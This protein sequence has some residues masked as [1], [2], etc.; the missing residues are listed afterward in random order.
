VRAKI[1]EP[2][3]TRQSGVAPLRVDSI[4]ASV[5]Q[6]ENRKSEDFVALRKG[7]GY[8]W[9]VAV[10][11]LPGEGKRLMEKWLVDADR[12]VRWIM[13]ENLKK[14]RLARVDASWVKAWQSRVG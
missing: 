11:A 10:A 6:V 1:A 7:L 13:K 4:T 8:C 3:E 9:S 14:N 5:R 2:A 12:D